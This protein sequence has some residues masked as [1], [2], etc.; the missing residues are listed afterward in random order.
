MDVDKDD[1]LSAI[2][3]AKEIKEPWNFDAIVWAIAKAIER[4]KASRE[5]RVSRRRH[6]CQLTHLV[7]D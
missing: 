1:I 2:R 4:T 7:G 3:F 6:R 5:S